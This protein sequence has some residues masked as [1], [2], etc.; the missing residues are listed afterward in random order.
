MTPEKIVEKF[1]NSLKHLELIDGQPS[2]TDLTRIR[3]IVAPLLL[4]I[5]YEETVDVHNLIGLIQLEAAY[6][7][8]YCAAFLEPT[9]VGAYDAAIDDYATAVV[10]ARTEAAHK[11]KRVDRATYET[12]RRETEQFILAVA[13]DTWVREI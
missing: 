2:D 1:A 5:L 12:A 4:Q 7:M 9:R 6:T 10:R 8:R 11:A 3:E 13:E